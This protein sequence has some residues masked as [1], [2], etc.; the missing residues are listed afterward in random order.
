M[1]GMKHVR[2]IRAEFSINSEVGDFGTRGWIAESAEAKCHNTNFIKAYMHTN[3]Q[4]HTHTHAVRATKKAYFLYKTTDEH[5]CV[6]WMFIT[7]AFQFVEHLC[8]L[9]IIWEAPCTST[10][11]NTNWNCV[12]ICSS[13]CNLL[14]V[15]QKPHVVGCWICTVMSCSAP[16]SM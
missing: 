2:C 16:E 9:S 5:D 7:Y 3:T 15:F 10:K 1:P 12:Y 11:S 14:V 13:G 8:L 4:T 6:L